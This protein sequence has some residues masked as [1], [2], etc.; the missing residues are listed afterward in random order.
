M[1]EKNRKIFEIDGNEIIAELETNKYYISFENYEKQRI[2]SEIP[3]DVFEAYVASKKIYYKNENEEKRHWER[4]QLTE[5][6]IYKRA[7]KYQEEIETTIINKDIK[8]NLHTAISKIPLIQRKRIKMKYFQE[9]K[10]R[11]IAEKERASI[12]AVQYS[13]YNGIK[14][15]KKFL[16]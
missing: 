6:S 15:L 11:E 9:M 10:E 8:A 13:L 12:R 3:K 1:K 14:N 4:S 5:I 2:T 7:T 16:N